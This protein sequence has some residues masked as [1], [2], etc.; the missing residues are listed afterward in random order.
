LAAAVLAPSFAHAQTSGFAPPDRTEG[1]AVGVVA[2]V[3]TGQTGP[4]GLLSVRLGVPVGRKVGLDFDLGRE[5][6][7]GQWGAGW[8]PKGFA[9]GAHLRGLPKGRS[10][11]GW[12][13][14][15]FLGPR[16]VQTERTASGGET[17][18]PV[19]KGFDF[20]GFG[21]DRVLES[22][23]RTG[24]ELGFPSLVRGAPIA[25]LNGFALRIPK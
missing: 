23:Y 7:N 10:A 13:G 12:S 19:A 3:A 2:T 17:T 8:R 15:L 11:G 24:F 4:W 6:G 16:F 9:G 21:L 1:F 14:Y 25:Q 20:P 22:G 5:V 18:R